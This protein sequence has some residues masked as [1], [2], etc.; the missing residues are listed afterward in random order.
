MS[1]IYLYQIHCIK[2]NHVYV[3]SSLNV[4]HVDEKYILVFWGY[5]C[6]EY[7]LYSVVILAILDIRP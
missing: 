1:F 2:N 3:K 5:I 4:N 6:C 7:V